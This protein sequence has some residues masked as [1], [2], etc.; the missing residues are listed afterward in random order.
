MSIDYRWQ[1]FGGILLDG[2]GDIA[3]TE[4]TGLESLQDMVRSRLKAALNGWKLYSIG[5]DLQ[6]TLG[7]AAIQELE[8]TIN[9]MVQQ[10][11][12]KQFLQP[13]VFQVETLIEP[14][15]GNAGA[16]AS[17]YVFLNQS[18]IATAVVTQQLPV[19]VTLT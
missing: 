6:S 10:S 14:T 19:D 7:Q 15:V 3:L 4:P 13:G 8:T 11:L 2:T 16:T 12:T 17:V 5:A 1:S 18:L 9:R